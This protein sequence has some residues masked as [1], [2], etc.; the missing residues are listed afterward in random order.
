MLH[1]TFEQVE[2]V[3]L[4]DERHLTVNLGKLG[5]T[6]GAEVLVTEAAHDLEVAVH[7]GHHQ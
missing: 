1:E 4:F 7:A 2:D 3:F 6:V 5:L